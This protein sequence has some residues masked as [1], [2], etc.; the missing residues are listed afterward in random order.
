VNAALSAPY[1]KTYVDNFVPACEDEIITGKG[2]GPGK[3]I[4]V[5]NR[6][7][8]STVKVEPLM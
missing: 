1:G 2:G 6:K 5:K 4:V 3:W 7:R 8:W